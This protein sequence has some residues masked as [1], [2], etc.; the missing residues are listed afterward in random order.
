MHQ[1]QG[2]RPHWSFCSISDVCC[3]NF[4]N[5]ASK[6]SEL[7]G[8]VLPSLSFSLTFWVVV[9]AG[10]VPPSTLKPSLK[11]TN[12][13]SSSSDKSK[14]S[15]EL[16]LGFG[17][18]GDRSQIILRGLVLM[19]YHGKDMD[20]KKQTVICRIIENITHVNVHIYKYI[21]IEARYVLFPW[22]SFY[23]F[24]RIPTT[25]SEY[26]E[27]TTKANIYCLKFQEYIWKHHLSTEKCVFLWFIFPPNYCLYFLYIYTQIYA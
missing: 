3:F 4:W 2:C 27:P 23:F 25:W 7:L 15:V 11:G 19:K 12:D 9:F 10:V 18:G 17:H 13:S 16:S 8:F 22:I 21:K 5:L 14:P 20:N 6:S 26:Q 24:K 1:T